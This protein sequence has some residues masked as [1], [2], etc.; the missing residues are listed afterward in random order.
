MAANLPEKAAPG[1][2]RTALP[3]KERA[4]QLFFKRAAGGVERVIQPRD[5]RASVS[6]LFRHSSIAWGFTPRPVASAAARACATA[7][8]SPAAL[9]GRFPSAL[10][11]GL[12]LLFE[13]KASQIERVI[14][15]GN[16]W[17]TTLGHLRRAASFTFH[18][19]QTLSE[20]GGHVDG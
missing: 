8:G 5:T 13:S 16:A 2:R 20:Q 7:E 3:F 1:G 6:N 17:A 10:R 15:P 9:L 14:Q 4:V 11:D 18:R 19:S 12:E